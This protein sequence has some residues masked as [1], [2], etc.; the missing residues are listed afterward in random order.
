M[1]QY[2]PG[3]WEVLSKRRM[4]ISGNIW[5]VTDKAGYPSAFVPAWDEPKEGE[6]DGA[7]EAAANARLIAAAPE[8]LGLLKEVR[9][10]GLIYW[11]PNTARGFETKALMLAR[12]DGLIA[13][14]EGGS[15]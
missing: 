14:I 2:T 9:D 5:R 15:Q 3:P 8:M 12:V 4:S 6:E 13:K 11:E 1:A 7:L 10:R